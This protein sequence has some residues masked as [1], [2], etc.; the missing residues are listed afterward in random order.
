MTT[1]PFVLEAL[2]Q[3]KTWYNTDTQKTASTLLNSIQHSDFVVGLIVL[4]K[5]SASNSWN[6]FS[7]VLW[8][9]KRY[10]ESS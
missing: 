8:N 7:R 1:L 9:D 4:E 3:M 10:H 2:E 6:G 5:I